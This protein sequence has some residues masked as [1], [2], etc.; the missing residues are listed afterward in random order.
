ML[1]FP[2]LSECSPMSSNND[3]D[4]EGLYSPD[5]LAQPI[6]LMTLE[7]EVTHN[8]PESLV[9]GKAL[10]GLSFILVIWSIPKFL[11]L[12]GLPGRLVIPVPHLATQKQKKL[13]ILRWSKPPCFLDITIRNLYLPVNLSWLT[14][15]SARLHYLPNSRSNHLE[16]SKPFD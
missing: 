10:P 13:R 6:A 9:L 16:S 12:L 2:P 8:E 7:K 1:H 11:C 14:Q 15:L 3:K 5:R 4:P